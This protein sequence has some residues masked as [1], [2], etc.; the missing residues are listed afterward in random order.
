M[1]CPVRSVAT[2]LGVRTPVATLHQRGKDIGTR[3]QARGVDSAKG[4]SVFLLGSDP[5]C[6]FPPDFNSDALNLLHVCV[7]RHVG[8]H[9]RTF[10]TV[11]KNAPPFGVLGFAQG[12]AAALLTG[13]GAVLA[14]QSGPESR[15]GYIYHRDPSKAARPGSPNAPRRPSFWLLLRPLLGFCR[16]A[17][18][19]F[20]PAIRSE[21]RGTASLPWSCSAGWRQM[22]L[23]NCEFIR[24]FCCGMLLTA[25]L[26]SLPSM[27]L[28]CFLDC[29]LRPGGCYALPRAIRCHLSRGPNPGGN[30]ASKRERP[31]NEIPGT[32]RRLRQRYLCLSARERPELPLPA[33]F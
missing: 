11:L 26:T 8:P 1:H 7:I 18:L 20:F 21:V 19:H 23:I 13:I 2:C 28:F 9:S 17:Y 32:G 4:I 25:S 31:R 22:G 14:L 24:A 12:C 27:L 30:P 16:C 3:Y 6:L 29:L 33:R 10:F 5:S 15:G